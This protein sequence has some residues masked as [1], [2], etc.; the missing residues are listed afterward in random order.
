[1]EAQ[2]EAAGRR[3]STVMRQGDRVMP[4]SSSST[5]SS[6][7]HFP[8]VAGIMLAA[9]GLHEVLAHTEDPLHAV[10]AFAL[11][12][13]VAIYLLGHVAVRLRGA[14]TLSRRRLALALILFAL[15]PPSRRSPRCLRDDRLRDAGVRR[16]PGPGAPGVR[17]RG[18]DRGV[19][20]L[21]TGTQVGRGTLPTARISRSRRPRGA[22]RASRRR[23][24]RR[25]A[26][27][28]SPRSSPPPRARAGSRLRAPAPATG[29]RS[30]RRSRPARP[31]PRPRPRS[32]GSQSCNLKPA[33]ERTGCGW[34]LWSVRGRRQPA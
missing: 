17:G 21:V 26:R 16:R 34:A 15:S 31:S 7:L 6:Y 5:W 3:L 19:L 24:W 29:R 9:V 11:L 13:G 25:G 32:S 27:L 23:G 30:T 4:S 14:R 33:C 8:L 20:A 18:G 1:M 2:P 12:G 28:C 22:S 10:P